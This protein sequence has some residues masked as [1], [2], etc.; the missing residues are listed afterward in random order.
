MRLWQV[1]EYGG[2]VETDQMVAEPYDIQIPS[3]KED[4]LGWR[5]AEGAGENVEVEGPVHVHYVHYA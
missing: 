4:G 3:E 5:G 1:V 2:G